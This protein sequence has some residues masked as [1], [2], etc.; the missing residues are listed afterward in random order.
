[1]STSG[2]GYSFLSEVYLF[3]SI[4]A[5]LAGGLLLSYSFMAGRK[6]ANVADLR[7]RFAYYLLLMSYLTLPPVSLKLFQ[8]GCFIFDQDF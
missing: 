8:V 2:L 3:A 5:V 7:T 1:M 6:G 4:P